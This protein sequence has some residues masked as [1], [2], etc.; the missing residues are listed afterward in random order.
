MR[1]AFLSHPHL[2]TRLIMKKCLIFAMIF[3]VAVF[4][5]SYVTAS[6]DPD[7]FDFEDCEDVS[8]IPPEYETGDF[9]ANIPYP[10]YWIE[11][12]C[13]EAILGCILSPV[14]SPGS[15]ETEFE[16]V[17]V[18]PAVARCYLSQTTSYYE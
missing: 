14:S 3:I 4:A 11:T 15:P 1:V 12:T 16:C 2:I 6:S 7:P 18:G 9:I 13:G 5:T 10:G 17:Y 8:E